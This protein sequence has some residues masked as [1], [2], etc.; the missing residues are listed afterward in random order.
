MKHQILGMSNPFLRAKQQSG[1]SNK[2]ASALNPN[3]VRGPP[4]N[5][6]LL[7]QLDSLNRIQHFIRIRQPDVVSLLHRRYR[8]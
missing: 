1:T 5:A 3:G 7:R 2:Q 4:G 8:Q 6:F